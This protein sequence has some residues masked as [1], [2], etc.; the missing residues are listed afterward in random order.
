MVLLELTKT[1]PSL[2][3]A[4]ILALNKK[5]VIVEDDAYHPSTVIHVGEYF[6][7]TRLSKCF[8]LKNSCHQPRNP[9]TVVLFSP[10][11]TDQDN[12]A[13]RRVQGI[14]VGG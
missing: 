3:G 14:C 1:S 2:Q 4:H 12:E 5:T 10:H 7:Y 11:F 8:V 13:N 9:V 6:I